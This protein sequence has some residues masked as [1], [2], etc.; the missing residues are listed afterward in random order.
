MLCKNLCKGTKVTALNSQAVNTAH[1][2]LDWNVQ[3]L[4]PR[5]PLIPLMPYWLV[6]LF[7][8]NGSTELC[9]TLAHSTIVELNNFSVKRD[10]LSEFKL[11]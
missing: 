10:S 2:C 8:K 4:L 6:T 11:E 7:K 9:L 1:T 3:L 5:T